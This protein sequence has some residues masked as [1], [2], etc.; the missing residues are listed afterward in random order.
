MTGPRIDRTVRNS[1][2]LAE[3]GGAKNCSPR[4]CHEGACRGAEKQKGLQCNGI[5]PRN[6]LNSAYYGAI[7]IKQY[8]TRPNRDRPFS[9]GFTGVLTENAEWPLTGADI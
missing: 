1:P 4:F 5:L 6:A 2:F 3:M 9:V 7:A 8:H